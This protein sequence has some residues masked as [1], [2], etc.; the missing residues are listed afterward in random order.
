[1][2][3]IFEITGRIANNLWIRAIH[4]FKKYGET[5]DRNDLKPEQWCTHLEEE[6]MDGLQYLERV[7]NAVSLLQRANDIISYYEKNVITPP[8]AASE[9]L[10]DYDKQFGS[11]KND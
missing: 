9:W 3:N 11:V 2:N 10:K 7:K 1:M 8:A 4:G 6:L 5:M